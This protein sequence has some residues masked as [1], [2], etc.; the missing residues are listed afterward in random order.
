MWDSLGSLRVFWKKFAC[1]FVRGFGLSSM[2]GKV[3][4][5]GSIDLFN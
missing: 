5:L 1:V 4:G 3:L 2:V